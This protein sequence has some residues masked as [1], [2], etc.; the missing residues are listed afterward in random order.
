MNKLCKEYISEVK[1]L[2]PIIRK[3]ERDYIKKIKVDIE[4]FCEEA[5]VTTKQELY[6]NYGRP[7]DVV[8]N[9]LST[10]ETEYIAKQISIK[11]LITTCV[12]ALLV[13]ATVATS[14]LCIALYTQY[15]I[16][17][18]SEMVKAEYTITEQ[19]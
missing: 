17:K 10:V 3:S 4:N 12:V 9:Y 1:A 7:N 11:R 19:N 8:N 18:R 6:E 2:F 14:A 5:E 15:Q 16:V 13:L